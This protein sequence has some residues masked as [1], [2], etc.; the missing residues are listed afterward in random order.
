MKTEVEMKFAE[1]TTNI[2]Q[3]QWTMIMGSHNLPTCCA[4]DL[5]PPGYRYA[6]GT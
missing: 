6:K 3:T 4:G 5:Y 1:A 2:I